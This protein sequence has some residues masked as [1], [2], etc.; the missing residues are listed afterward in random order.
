MSGSF[1]TTPAPAE[2]AIR[3]IQP[4]RVSIAHSLKRQSRTANAQRW[5]LT[6]QFAPLTHEQLAPL[7]AF[8]VSQRGRYDTFT[9][10]LPSGAKGPWPVRGALGGAPLVNNQVG[11]PEEVQ[12]GRTLN[13]NGCSLNITNWAKAG[14]FFKVSGHSKVY[15][16]TANV[17]SNGSGQAALTIDP[18]LVSGPAHGEALTFSSVPFTVALAEDTQEVTARLRPQYGFS[19]ELIEA[20]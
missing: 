8:I 11:S 13:I 4:A 5:G 3:T 1:P 7:F 16:V 17:D 6:L 2:I 19:L 15:M 12:T 14:D 18:A 20:Y 10:T 9:Y